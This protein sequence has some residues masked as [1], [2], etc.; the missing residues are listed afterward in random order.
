MFPATI[1]LHNASDL[2]KVMS[3]LYPTTGVVEITDK[4]R[5]VKTN[6]A[7]LTTETKVKADPKPTAVKTEQPAASQ[8]TAEEAK[9][10]APEKKDEPASDAKSLTYAADVKPVM[11]AKIKA[12]HRDKCVALLAKFKVDHGEKLTPEQLPGFLDELNAIGAE[13]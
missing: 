4:A 3:V 5:D 8:P 6:D 13:A 12:G 7:A 1:T 2:Q 11:L 10:A 9:A